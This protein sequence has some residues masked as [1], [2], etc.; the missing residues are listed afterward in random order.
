MSIA[1]VA[2]KPSV[3]RDIARALGVKGR[4]G[5]GGLWGNGYVVTWALGH[6]VG[7]AEPHQVNPEWKRWQ[8][9]TLPMFPETWPLVVLEKTRE[10]FEQVSAILNAPDVT[11]VICATDAGREGE[12]IF[13]FLYEAVGCRKPV[14]RLWL[15]SL[16]ESAIRA[17]FLNL[18]P[19]KALD[20]LA[21]AAL[22]RA[23]A[24]WLVGMNFSRGYGLS[25]AEPLSV[26]RVQTP[27][28]AMLVARELEIRAFVPE[29]YLEVVATFSPSDGV[30]YRGT[31]HQRLPKDGKEAE[32]VVLRAR[33]G[34]ARVGELRSDVK[35]IPPPLLHDLTEL[36]R[37]ANRLYGLSAE[38][39]LD[40]A[41]ALYE[42]HKLL[43]YPR[44][45]SR[46]LSTDIAATLPDIIAAVR[47]PFEALLAPG[48]GV[49]PLSRRFVDNAQV[50]DHHALIPTGVSAQGLNLSADERRIYELVCR[51]LLMAW[52]ADFVWETTSLETHVRPREAPLPI[53]RYASSGTRV[54]GQG[55]K[56]LELGEAPSDSLLPAELVT[57]QL[58]RVLEV[59]AVAKRTRP[60]KRHT[61][62][63]LLS[64]MEGAGRKLEEKELSQAMR[65]CG[66]GTPAT[67]ASIIE[68]LLS[69]G[70]IQRDA[71]LLVPTERGIHLI[72]VVDA[73]V[74]SP[75]M[76]GVWEARLKKIERGTDSAQAF[77]AAIEHY[78]SEV[79]GRIP[80]GGGGL[81]AGN[82]G[83]SPT[84]SRNAPP[85]RLPTASVGLGKLL[86]D[87]FGFPGFRPHQEEVCR[88]AT[89]GEDVLLVMPTGAGKSLCYQLPGLARGGTTLVV[90]PLIALMEDQVQKLQALGLAAERIHSG[91]DRP[92]SRQVC[93]D[94]LSGALDYLFIAPER[95]A[96]PGFVEMLARRLPTLI[97]VDE[98]HCIS[99]WGHDFRPDYR[100]LGQRLPSLRPA[101]VVALTATAT[102]VVQRDIAEQLGLKKA[103]VFIHGFRRENLALEVLELNPKARQDKAR[104]LLLDPARRPA[105]LYA[106]TRK[107]AESLA[108]SLGD[109][110]SVSAY[111]AGMSSS[112]RDEVQ[113]RFLSGRLEVVVATVAFG[114]GVDKADVRTVIHMGLPS[115]L[116]GY[117]QEIGRAGRDG[118]MSRAFLFHAFVDRHTHI[119]FHERDY[120]DPEVLQKIFRSL[121]PRWEERSQVAARGRVSTELFEKALE[122]LLIHG[123]VEL[124]AGGQVRQGNAAW[125]AAYVGQ[126]DRRLAQLAQMARF[127]ES[128][129]CRMLHVVRH[130][131]D[132][133]D[134]GTPCGH[135]DVCAP[136]HC[137]A[138]RFRAAESEDVQNLTAIL[139]ALRIWD[140]QGT[141]RLCKQTVG[142]SPTARDRFESYLGALV[143]AG[144]VAVS[145][146]TFEKDG[147]KIP[148][149]KA[150]LSPAGRQAG[151][152][153]LA[154][155]RILS[156]AK[157]AST[158]KGQKRGKRGAPAKARG[159]APTGGAPGSSKWVETL[160][161]WRRE[162]ARRRKVP[163]YRILTNR[164][165]EA[166]AQKRPVTSVGLQGVPGIGPK[167]AETYGPALL[168]LLR[169]GSTIS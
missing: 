40:L 48:T 116:E 5:L 99:Q 81:P 63:S 88:A 122:K 149:L 103:N 130:F 19:Q 3:A 57:G 61:E 6:L 128:H 54:M 28:L 72:E 112:A 67:R 53:D 120:P 24:D 29:D 32:A 70:Y 125:R 168:S 91:R 62:G 64:A 17:G 77:L 150:S 143:R 166:L 34:L 9:Q 4:G 27:T 58:Q 107:A 84:P 169:A 158:A 123:G 15:S 92:A 156:D 121:T 161:V 14:R 115:S 140:G 139:A 94:Y 33:N 133:A 80:R 50:T 132:G 43:S 110:C 131:G 82:G 114:M 2:E 1:V 71:K 90:S 129:D 86:K 13:R 69:R 154:A 35:R 26:G 127:A 65:D 93:L 39:T 119:F 109:V 101:P 30:S 49:A 44:T 126:R 124:Q 159:R 79:L 153:E 89:G 134:R 25:L 146:A 78:I 76:T 142:E 141:G 167:T 85:R 38:R 31:Y 138:V 117:Y 22:A 75:E 66:L 68:T 155:L 160:S 74:K 10:Q 95:L 45:G 100:L 96:I 144:L 52:H 135:C 12:L 108:E 164:A 16:T 151:W 163:A 7:L 36:Q 87:V 165:L 98:A 20:G 59:E 46:H 111:H 152:A 23:R 41:Q 157:A 56:A 145:E 83:A 118:K 73:A 11:E 51:R 8:W 37:Q 47:G 106:T 18:K 102:P 137:E 136:E 21:S 162:E 104:E 42:R 147:E 148:F 60:P 97:A 105:I 55:W 113:T